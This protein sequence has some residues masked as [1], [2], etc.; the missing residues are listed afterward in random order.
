MEDD[1]LPLD[2]TD[3]DERAWIIEQ[4]ALRKDYLTIKKEF[5]FLFAPKVVSGKE[6]MRIHKGYPEQLKQAEAFILADLSAARYI[7]A[8]IRL[9]EIAEGIK[10][11]KE[12]VLLGN[13]KITND[14]GVDEWVEKK[15]YDHVARCKYLALAQVEEFTMKKLLLEMKRLELDAPEL[16]RSG[17]VSITVNAGDFED[18]VPVNRPLINGS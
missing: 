2:Q 14:K 12:K 16:R 4:I 3:E 17:T 18:D 1:F 10:Q 7:H 15:D 6:I 11:T 9:E 5:D 8:R 13:V